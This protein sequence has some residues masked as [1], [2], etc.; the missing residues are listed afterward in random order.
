MSQGDKSTLEEV[1]KK[2]IS[3]LIEKSMEKNW[4]VVIPKVGED[5]SDKLKER[6]N[7]PYIRFDCNYQNAKAL[8]KKD[9]LLKELT[10]HDGNI[11]QLAKFIG[12]N[13]RSIHRSIKELGITFNKNKSKKEGEKSEETDINQV[14]KDTI[15][16]YKT[17]IQDD[18]IE[19]MYDDLPYLSKDIAK[20]IPH[21]EM[22]WKQAEKIFEIEY[23]THHLKKNK[24]IKQL[25]I[26][27][28]LRSETVS[29]KLKRLNIKK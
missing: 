27:I 6:K 13:R 2:K 1:I 22:T 15:D 5:I 4:G 10:K 18:K 11:S 26:K 21:K 17:L 16:Q 28:G 8:F 24:N 19:K 3:P 25:A 7:H 14:I 12:L 23:L 29:R 20:T 9:F